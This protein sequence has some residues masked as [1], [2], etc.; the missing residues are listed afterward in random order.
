MLL[1][2]LAHYQRLAAIG[3]CGGKDV[4]VAAVGK[5]QSLAQLL[6]A[7]GKIAHSD[8]RF[9]QFL[10]LLYVG[11]RESQDLYNLKYAPRE[12]GYVCVRRVEL[13][14]GVQLVYVQPLRQGVVAAGFLNAG[15]G[16]VK[17]FADFIAVCC[18]I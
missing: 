10:H 5:L 1:Y 2:F 7:L 15:V 4:A 8:V 6:Y 16:L 3:K 18:S 9:S 14:V 13:A 11:F 17:V 12:I